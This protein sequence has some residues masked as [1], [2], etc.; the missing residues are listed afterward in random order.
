MRL[1]TPQKGAASIE[2]VLGERS[3]LFPPETSQTR[4]GSELHIF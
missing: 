3:E 2:C 4:I 1:P